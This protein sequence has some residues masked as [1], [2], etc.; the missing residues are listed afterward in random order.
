MYEGCEIL[1]PEYWRRR[2][3]KE[4]KEKKAKEVE[5]TRDPVRGQPVSGTGKHRG[6]KGNGRP[7]CTLRRRGG[8]LIGCRRGERWEPKYETL[9]ERNEKAIRK[10]LCFRADSDVDDTTFEE[11]ER[12]IERWLAE[13]D[14]FQEAE[15]VL[16][17]EP[18]IYV[19]VDPAT[20]QEMVAWERG[21]LG[22]ELDGEDVGLEDEDVGLEDGDDGGENGSTYELQIQH[23]LNEGLEVSGGSVR[24][25]L[26]MS[27]Q[28]W[29]KY[30]WDSR[31]ERFKKTLPEAHPMYLPSPEAQV[32]MRG[33]EEF[34]Q[35]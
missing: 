19:H 22:E 8:R 12:E 26:S 24:R 32:F 27:S 6:D 4:K 7:R 17:V 15:E 35:A 3:E 31:R 13:E 10:G 20:S 23:L 14:A 11:H 28:G 21:E 16:E 30:R 29:P 33:E 9:K 1:S 34:S 25:K 5:W 18:M 2:D